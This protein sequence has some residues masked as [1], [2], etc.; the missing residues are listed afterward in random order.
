[1][2]RIGIDVTSALTQ[3]GGI[4]RYTRELIRELVAI[5]SQTDYRLFSAR[6]PA[7]SPVPNPL[8]QAKNVT[9]TPTRLDERWLYRLWY[10]ARLPL[11][12][13]L[14][15]GKIDLFHSPDFVLPPT[16]GKIPTLLTVHDLSFLHYPKTFTPALVRYLN[17]VV[18]WSVGRATHILADSVSTMG[19]IVENYG[20]N[21]DKITVLLPGVTKNYRPVIDK[22]LIKRVR[23]KYKIDDAP[24]ILALGTVQPRKN[25][26]M[27]TRA[28]ASLAGNWPHNL[29]IAGGRGWLLEEISAEIDSLNLG[30]RVRF[31]GFVDDADLPALYS[32]ADIFTQPSLYEGFGFPILE[33]MACGVPVVSAETSSL[34]EVVG[35]AGIL[36]SPHDPAAWTDTLHKLLLNGSQRAAM[37]AAGSVQARKFTWRQAARQLKGVYDRL[38]A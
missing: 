23:T 10:R 5:D 36:L 6:P 34:P 33:A 28:F 24:Y 2:T 25:Y 3:G 1:M 29:V 37:V 8:P 12:V 21:E 35:D 11:P 14:A 9:H 27:L 22:K 38:L 13:Q 32:G 18:P 7:Q 15:T 31:L 26:A 16:L 30:D 19:D 4:G 17:A 20:V